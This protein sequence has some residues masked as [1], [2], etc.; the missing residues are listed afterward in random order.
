MIEKKNKTTLVVTTISEPQECLHLLSDGCKK[1]EWD[2]I[3]VGDEGSPGNFSISGA[4]YYDVD[5][6]LSTDL[7]TA[8]HCLRKHY[9]RKNIGYLLAMQNGSEIIVETDD[10][11]LPLSAFWSTRCRIKKVQSLL[12][13]GWV[14]IYSYFSNSNIWPR[15]LPLDQICQKIVPDDLSGLKEAICPIQQ[16][17]ANDNPDVDAIYRL[18]LPL[19]QTFSN[20]DAIA[21]GSGTWSPFNSQNTTWFKE[22]FPLMYL[23]CYC[24]FRMTDIWRSMI[25]QRIAW[26]NSWSVL[27][28][29][30]TV[31]QRRNEHNLMK[32]FK[33]EIPGYLQNDRIR[34][35]LDDIS[36]KSGEQNIPGALRLCYER[37]VKSAIFD[38]SELIL[39][40]VWL[41]DIK[42]LKI[43]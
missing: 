7:K 14:N 2:F 41:Q 12:K 8:R 26:E 22:A 18:I 32:D 43:E 28:H 13:T 1:Y 40:D 4:D 3:I 42:S 30:P 33:D 23:P 6:Q 16:G 29:G 39:L 36:I 19:P 27:F 20:A 37:L 9:A 5:R 17:L 21:L 38:E 25:A 31:Y 35:L 15:G 10:D 34:T 24:S 11:N